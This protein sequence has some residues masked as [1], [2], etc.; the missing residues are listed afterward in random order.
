MREA[1]NIPFDLLVWIAG[2]LAVVLL[3]L[4]TLVVV[5]M[6]FTNEFTLR[7]PPRSWSARWYLELFSNSPQI[8]SSALASLKVAAIATLV[9]T[10]LGTLAAVAL[11]GR[12]DRLSV[13]LDAFFMSPMVFPAM[14]LGL[15]L[16]LV[17]SLAGIRLS[18]LTLAIGHVVIA[19]PFVIR[20]VSASAQQMNPALLDCAASLGASRVHAFFTITLPLIR[21]GVVSGAIVAFLTSIDHVPVSLMLSDPRTETLP[22]HLWAILESNL[23]VRVAAVSGVIVAATVAVMLVVDRRMFVPGRAGR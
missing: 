14:S 10:V 15:A 3:V 17:L 18:L 8:L 4:P 2:A 1:R 21:S 23:D 11:A 5:A 19:T 16:L 7:F 22:I 9:S 13:A 20:M 6:S 12:K